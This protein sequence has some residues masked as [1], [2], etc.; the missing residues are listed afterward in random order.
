MRLRGT[1]QRGRTE[2][3]HIRVMT[4]KR[5]K[6]GERGKEREGRER[7][8]RGENEHVYINVAHRMLS[9]R[10][11][12]AK[13]DGREVPQSDC[14]ERGREGEGEREREREEMNGWKKGGEEFGLSNLSFFLSFFLSLSLYLLGSQL[15]WR[16]SLLMD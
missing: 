1:S 13:R 5:G 9:S 11:T 3:E 10:D 4:Y 6:R 16:S 8:E 15:Q 12:R 2:Q 14:R 7:E